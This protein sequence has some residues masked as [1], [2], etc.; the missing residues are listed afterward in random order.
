[1]ESPNNASSRSRKA[2]LVAMSAR[3]AREDGVPHLQRHPGH[4]EFQ[5]GNPLQLRH[6]DRVDAIGRHAEA[7]HHVPDRAGGRQQRDQQHT[8]DG[9]QALGQGHV[10]EHQASPVMVMPVCRREDVPT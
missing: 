1:M 5:L 9:Q 7:A 4:V 3:V 8:V 6:V 2:R 10:L